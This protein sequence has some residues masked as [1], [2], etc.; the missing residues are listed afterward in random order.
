[1]DLKYI[2][3]PNTGRK[4]TVD[5]V[6]GNRILHRYL[7]Q[8]GGFVRSNS[9]MPTCTI[10]SQS[11]G[12]CAAVGKKNSSTGKRRCKKH[13]K[14][15]GKC[16]LNPGTKRCKR[17][18]GKKSN[19]AAKSGKKSNTAAK[20][21]KKSDTNTLKE[22]PLTKNNR[23]SA[24]AYYRKFEKTVGDRCNIRKDGTLKCLL[25]DKNDRPIWKSKSKKIIYKNCEDWSSKCKLR[26]F[27]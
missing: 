22:E 1:M 9:R 21:G 20:S 25:L 6:I 11:G 15:D 24:G 23:L 16:I 12:E 4:V 3:N 8:S 17:V 14:S 7:S 2:I 26:E 13:P 5:G 10:Y 18:S 19:T 27:A